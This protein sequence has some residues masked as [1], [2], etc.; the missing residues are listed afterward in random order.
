MIIGSMSNLFVMT[1]PNYFAPL[2]F[3][4]SLF[5]DSP[6]PRQ[7]SFYSYFGDPMQILGLFLSIFQLSYYHIAM[8]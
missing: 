7:D 8:Q 6:W 1:E 3:E 4:R 5:T 2:D